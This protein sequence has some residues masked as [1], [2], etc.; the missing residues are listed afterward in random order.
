MIAQIKGKVIQKGKD[1]IIIDVCGICYKVMIP[2]II[3][4]R[5]D[6]IITED[7][8][9][10]LI[11][12]HYLQSEPSKSQPVL[13]GF[14]NEIEKEFFEQFIKVAG[15]GPRAAMRAFNQPI[16][17]IAQAI[18]E[19]DLGL[20]NSLPGIGVQRAKEIIAKLQGK[21][22]K[23][24]LIK[25]KKAKGHHIKEDWQEG[26]LQILIQLQYK[27]Q[28]A[29]EMIRKALERASDINNTE[30]LLNE[31]YRQKRVE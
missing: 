7:G 6:E 19:G 27:K 21:V 28:E 2:P 18:D 14:L 17:N 3:L 8:N 4:N 22:G 10:S 5:V 26:A 15:I 1:C 23:F 30:E 24:G 29:K 9:I 11:T 12:Y 16:S 31:V 13:I 20:L 25:D